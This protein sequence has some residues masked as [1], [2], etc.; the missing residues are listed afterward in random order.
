VLHQQQAPALLAEIRQIERAQSSA[1]PASALGKACRYTLALWD[2]LTRFLADPELV[3]RNNLT[4]HSMRPVA[5]CRKNWIH[6]WAAPRP[7]PNRIR[8]I[9]NYRAFRIML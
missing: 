9:R 7:A 5:G 3:L 4:E 8:N 6:T 2:K 1:L